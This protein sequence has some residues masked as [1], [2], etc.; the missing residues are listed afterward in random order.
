[1]EVFPDMCILIIHEENTKEIT[2]VADA[3]IRQDICV[4]LN[5]YKL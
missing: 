1:M 4:D 5:I 3:L 2:T